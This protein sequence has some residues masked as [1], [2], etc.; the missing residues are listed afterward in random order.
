MPK[1]VDTVGR[2]APIGDTRRRPAVLQS[3]SASPVPP[4]RTSGR[5][6]GPASG[7]STTSSRRRTRSWPDIYCRAVSVYRDGLI[8]ALRSHPG[9]RQAIRAAVDFHVRWIDAHRPLARIM[10][11]WDESEL[12]ED[13]RRMLD[14]ETRRFSAELDRW[15]KEA[16]G[17]GPSASVPRGFR[18]TVHRSAARVRA[19]DGA[20]H[21]R[22]PAGGR[23]RGAGR[24]DLGGVGRVTHLGRVDG[25]G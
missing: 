22:P 7:A 14:E 16:A 13:G 8:D 23:M 3:R 1:P 15:F 21:H 9:P 18:R 12:S 5:S 24:R 4:S 19:A 17:T 10:L 6:R 2:A 20:V 11:R 25:A